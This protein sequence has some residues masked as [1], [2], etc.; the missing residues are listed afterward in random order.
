MRYQKCRIV[1]I[2][3]ALDIDLLRTFTVLAEEMSF[4]AAGARLGATQSAVSV[5][6]RKLEERI[7]RAL[8]ER[9]PRNVALTAFGAG[10]L[11]DARR[12][13]AAHDEALARLTAADTPLALSFGVSEHAGGDL[14]PVA[15]RAMRDLMP[16]LKLRV[17]LGLSDGLIADYDHGRLDAVVIRRNLPAPGA[18]AGTSPGGRSLYR[19]DLVWAAAPGFV[20]LPGEPVPLVTIETPCNARTAAVDALEGAGLPYVDAFQSR[21]LAAIQAAAVA[22][23]GLA[24]LG[25][26]HVPAGCV[27]LGAAEGLPPLPASE[28][29]LYQRAREPAAVLAVM[30]FAEALQ[31]AA[32]GDR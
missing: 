23:L 21:G 31:A 17:T 30:R 1:I 2:M 20:W 10:F 19:D 4:T 27:I 7:G 22:G 25:E 24:C 12:I 9:T 8:F 13:L 32:R 16:R 29:V 15:L 6:L 28:V 5:R 11:S 26:R 14:L 18:P 3:S